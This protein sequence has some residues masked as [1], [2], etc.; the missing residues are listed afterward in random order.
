MSEIKRVTGSFISNL[1]DSIRSMEQHP[2]GLQTVRESL[3]KRFPAVAFYSGSDGA[4]NVQGLWILPLDD[5]ISVL[6]VVYEHESSDNFYTDVP[7][8]ENFD[9]Q[10][11]LYNGIPDVFF[12]M[13]YDNPEGDFLNIENTLGK[14]IYH[15]TDW[16]VYNVF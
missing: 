15:G 9:K 2:K 12:E 10:V 11:N 6:H 3:S 7:S 13:L 4:G 16:N 1:I 8:D 5:S 14:R